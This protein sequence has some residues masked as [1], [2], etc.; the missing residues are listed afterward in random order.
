VRAPRAENV[1]KALAVLSLTPHEIEHTR[2][3]NK[4]ANSLLRHAH[5]DMGGTKEEAQA[6]NGARDDVLAWLKA[7]RF[8]LGDLAADREN[9]ERARRAE[10]ARQAAEARARQEAEEAR[11]RQEA[12]RQRREA[13]RRAAAERERRVA[14][15]RRAIVLLFGLL[16]TALYWPRGQT[17]SAVPLTSSK[18]YSFSDLAPEMRLL[19]SASSYDE[20]IWNEHRKWAS[21]RS[22]LKCHY[23]ENKVLHFW[24]QEERVPYGAAWER[25]IR[26]H[27]FSDILSGA[28]EC[29]PKYPSRTSLPDGLALEIESWQA[30]KTFWRNGE[31]VTIERPPALNCLYLR[32]GSLDWLIFSDRKRRTACPK[33]YDGAPAT[34]VKVYG[35]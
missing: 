16:M 24:H 25:M 28:R 7:G 29:P 22:I 19:K 18:T 32:G 21:G 14:N 1:R 2:D 23:G 8:D 27:P 30:P 10:A 5:P 20:F 4:R 3:V 35:S 12:E 26:G 34:G 33:T 9:A 11:A 17:D 15:L 31:R 6:I 13:E